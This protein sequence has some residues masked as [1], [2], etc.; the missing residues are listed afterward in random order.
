MRTSVRL[1]WHE[2]SKYT[3][4][5]VL[6]TVA[7]DPGVYRLGY[8]DTAGERRVF[9][10]GQGG[11]LESRLRDHLRTSEP[12]DCIKRYVNAQR[13]YVKWAVVANPTHRDGAERALYDKFQPR[14]NEVRPG[15]PDFDI[16]FD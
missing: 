5:A 2:L 15:G 7:K 11:D 16:N 13:C 6:R 4:D 8:Y 10:V 12:N 3:D 1:T 14:C 9:Y